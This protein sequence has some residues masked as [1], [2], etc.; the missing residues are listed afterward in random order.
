L[1]TDRT[2]TDGKGDAIQTPSGSGSQPEPDLLDAK[3]LL[4]VLEG[5]V[6]G[7]FSAALAV[8]AARSLAEGPVTARLDQALDELDD[9]VR[10]LRHTALVSHLPTHTRP[11]P[12]AEP[13]GSGTSPAEP[14][15]DL[16]DQATG[17]L[18]DA[19]AVPVRL[20]SDAARGSSR[21]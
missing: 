17:A 3:I 6:R 18:T 9:V 7:I 16:V 12:H 4:H 11:R 1:A 2:R 21:A 10:E 8:S 5:V 14:T 20:G 19:D 13:G 15:P